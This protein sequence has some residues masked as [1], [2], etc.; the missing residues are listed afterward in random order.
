MRADSHAHLLKSQQLGRPPWLGEPL[1]LVT[2]WE[3]G[4]S[5]APGA[6]T[7]GSSPEQVGVFLPLPREP[8]PQPT[9]TSR[10]RQQEPLKKARAASRRPTACRAYKH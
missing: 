2:A 4:T 6:G 7:L 10:A 3:A 1:L 9:R 5:L 8:A